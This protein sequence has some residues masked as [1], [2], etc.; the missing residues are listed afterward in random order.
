M[1]NENAFKNM[2]NPV[3]V[4]KTSAVFHAHHSSFDVKRFQKI[5]AKL[6]D[7]EM[8]AR[9][10]AITEGLRAELPADFSASAQIISR[11]LSEKSLKG[12]ELWPISE[13]I[14]QFG[15]DH[16]DESLE[17]MY[18]LTQQFTSE[19]AIRPFLLKD[20][21]RI[22]KKFESWLEDDNVHIRRWISEGTRPLLPWGTKIP[23]FVAKP[24][25]I[26]L[27]DAL[28]YD[29][30]LYV[31]KSIAN[32]LNDVSKHHPDLVVETLKAW[33]KAAPKHHQDKIHWI[34]KQ[35]LR[36]LIK[37][38]HPK[39]LGLMGVTEKS[40]VKVAQLKLNKDKFKLGEILEFEFV[41]ESTGAKSQKIIVDY[42]IGFLKANGSI[43]TKMF[44][45]K[46]VEL[47]PRERLLIKKRH[48]LRAITTT[49][50]YSGKHE[51]VLQVNGKILKK[52]AWQFKV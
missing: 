44:K 42:G 5:S 11:V 9:V 18:Q 30:E 40:E 28:K 26:H 23:S 8:K 1:E 51:L 35:A 10:L 47:G 29:E 27:L 33:V 15:T 46:T 16:F 13:Y 49:T 36:T 37:K 21:T 48:S 14:S 6:N 22:L 32:H 2:I 3:V 34:K 50:F 24:A 43:S 41:L 25:T 12:F 39:A 4:K 31:R 38:G 52:T 17:L 7:L 45:L 20:P 19:F